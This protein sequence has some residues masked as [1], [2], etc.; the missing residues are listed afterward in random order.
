MIPMV[1]GIES[2]KNGLKLVFSVAKH[3]KLWSVGFSMNYYAVTAA[4][5]T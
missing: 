5:E 1:R 2:K 3:W 4:F